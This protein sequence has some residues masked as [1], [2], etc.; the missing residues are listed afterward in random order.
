LIVNALKG[1]ARSVA[2]LF[3]LGE[4]SGHFDDD[5]SPI[6]G[7][8]SARHRAAL[9]CFDHSVARNVTHP[10]SVNSSS[11][12]RN[13]ST[14]QFLPRAA[15]HKSRAAFGL[16]H[17]VSNTRHSVVRRLSC[18]EPICQ[19][20]TNS[21]NKPSNFGPK[22]TK[23][24]RSRPTKRQRQRVLAI[25]RRSD[26][27]GLPIQS[28][29][30]ETSTDRACPRMD[31]S[32]VAEREYCG[33]QRQPAGAQGHVR[34]APVIRDRVGGPRREITVLSICSAAAIG[35]SPI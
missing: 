1:E 12:E 16:A 17:R 2:T 11:D 26:V 6:T 29:K 4:Q 3:R 28:Q 9:F 27:L 13:R 23:E 10:L 33:R 25:C 15:R 5:Q 32:C 24:T 22:W 8:G 31:A 19:V 30:R 35:Y 18:Q 21:G 20:P 14:R 34:P 7:I